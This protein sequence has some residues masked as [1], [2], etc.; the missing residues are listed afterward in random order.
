MRVLPAYHHQ[1]IYISSMIVF[2]GLLCYVYLYFN[3][4]TNNNANLKSW[5]PR[6]L[7]LILLTTP[8]HNLPEEVYQVMVLPY[9]QAFPKVIIGLA[10]HRVDL[11]MQLLPAP[12]TVQA[13]LLVH[14]LEA[15]PEPLHHIG[16]DADDAS[17]IC[18]RFH[19]HVLFHLTILFLQLSVFFQLLFIF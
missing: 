15:T 3:A 17:Y 19:I 18:R 6:G 2:V 10:L 1:F 11:I 14:V 12:Y 5:P 16:P 9:V 8:V 4:L 13:G 7:L